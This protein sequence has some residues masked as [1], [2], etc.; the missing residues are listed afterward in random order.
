VNGNC[1]TGVSLRKRTEDVPV[2]MRQEI[3]RKVDMLPPALQEQVLRFVTALKGSAPAGE[4]G[5]ALRRFSGSLDSV[6]ARQ[7]IEAIE[8]ECE[9]VE[10]GEW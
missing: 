6:S 2:D 7:M 4:N 9:R 8:E 3:S 5:G 1:P 10:A